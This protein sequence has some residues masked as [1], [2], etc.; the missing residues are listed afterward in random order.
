MPNR[1]ARATSPYL[2]QHADNPVDWWEWGPT[3]GRPRPVVGGVCRV[4]LVAGD[5]THA[6]PGL[7][8]GR[9]QRDL[10]CD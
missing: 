1:L 6:Q 2:L 9:I 7:E 8:G 4:P 3:S 10:G 5:K